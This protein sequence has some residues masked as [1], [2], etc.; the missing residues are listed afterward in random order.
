MINN[1]Q[2]LSGLNLQIL[3]IGHVGK[4]I[5]IEL[6]KIKFQVVDGVEIGILEDIYVTINVGKY[7]SSIY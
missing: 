5:S 7:N 2:I 1:K 6:P 3:G 4:V